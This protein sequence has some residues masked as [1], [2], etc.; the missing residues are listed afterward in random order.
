MYLLSVVF[1]YTKNGIYVPKLVFY[2]IYRIPIMVSIYQNRYFAY[3]TYGIR[4][5]KLVFHIYQNWYYL[6]TKNGIYTNFGINFISKI[7]ILY[8][9]NAILLGATP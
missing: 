1:L 8:T 2:Q 3:T 7:R 4:I 5:P 9:Q 6:C